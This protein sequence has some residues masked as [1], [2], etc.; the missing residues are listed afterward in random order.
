[1]GSQSN[2]CDSIYLP[3]LIVMKLQ[4]EKSVMKG[5]GFNSIHSIH[6]PYSMPAILAGQSDD[7][8]TVWMSKADIEDIITF[9]RSIALNGREDID[10]FCLV[11]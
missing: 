9:V 7:D 4:I 8:S 11:N 3:G 2:L 10:K 5:K 6:S 1:M